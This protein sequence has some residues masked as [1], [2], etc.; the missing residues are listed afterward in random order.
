MRRDRRFWEARRPRGVLQVHQIIHR[1]S[2]SFYLGRHSAGRFSQ[3]DLAIPFP[4]PDPEYLLNPMLLTGNFAEGREVVAVD[5]QSR[6]IRVVEDVFQVLDLVT[7]VDRHHHRPQLRQCQ[8]GERKLRTVWQ[9]HA[10][11]MP[12]LDASL[13]QRVGKLI[14][15]RVQFGEAVT[16]A[17]MV[18]GE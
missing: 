1:R 6:G 14:D 2:R 17:L 18:D 11:V 13:L 8:P 4:W 12:S 15:P 9:H 16:H 7:I 10:D 5:Y 3:M